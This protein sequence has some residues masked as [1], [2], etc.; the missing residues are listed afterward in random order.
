MN[1]GRLIISAL[2]AIA[3]GG[4]CADYTYAKSKDKSV[5]KSNVVKAPVAKKVS[6]GPILGDPGAGDKA[7]FGDVTVNTIAGDGSGLTALDAANIAAGSVMSAVDGSAITNLSLGIGSVVQAY[8]ANLSKLALNDGGSLTNLPAA[9]SM[10]AANLIAGTVASAIDG[11]AITNLSLGIGSVVQAY[12]ANLDKLALND[13]GSLTNLQI[14]V[15]SVVQ[16]YS[17]NLDK[18]ALNDGGSLT[19]VTAASMSA[20]DLTAGTIASA[21]DGSAIT[22]LS[23]GVGSVVQAYSANLD[24]LALNDGG[25]LTNLQIGVG[26]VVQAYSANLDKLALNDGGSLTNITATGTTVGGYMYVTWAGTT[27]TVYVVSADGLTTNVMGT[28]WKE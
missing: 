15:G 5:S 20:A 28:Y 6:K 26:S 21:I 1:Y 16:A 3:I 10:S 13:G 11:S 19:N 24:K 23:L 14:G 18:L 7:I 9:T 8:S 22:N 27:S 4:F 17:A 12:S 2:V 25:S